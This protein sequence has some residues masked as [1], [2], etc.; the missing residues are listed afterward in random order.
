MNNL[1]LLINPEIMKLHTEYTL[2]SQELKASEILA[3][4]KHVWA[5][6][7]NGTRYEKELFQCILKAER[8]VL[9]FRKQLRE[10]QERMFA[11]MKRM[12]CH[13]I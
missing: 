10:V 2:L 4:L 7:P 11:I 12:R 1:I 8:D 5:E 13:E 9:L 3:N 6:M